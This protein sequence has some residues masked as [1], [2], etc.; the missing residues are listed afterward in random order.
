MIARGGPGV[1]SIGGRAP[2]EVP[3]LVASHEP[4]PDVDVA[5]FVLASLDALL[6]T[7]AELRRG[8]TP[9]RMTVPAERWHLAAASMVAARRYAADLAQ[10]LG[11]TRAGTAPADPAGTPR[12]PRN[13]GIHRRTRRTPPH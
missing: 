9:G 12:L 13:A 1:G 5:T 11:A 3:V 7:Q 6:E 2:E 4:H 8:L 10:A